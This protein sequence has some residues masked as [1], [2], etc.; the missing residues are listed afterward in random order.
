MTALV[1]IVFAY[2]ASSIMRRHRLVMTE[3]GLGELRC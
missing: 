3:K 2:I 1:M